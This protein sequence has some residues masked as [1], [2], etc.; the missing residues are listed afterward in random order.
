MKS[1]RNIAENKF[2][3]MDELS[4][5]CIKNAFGNNLKIMYYL[6]EYSV[7]LFGSKNLNI[8]NFYT[9]GDENHYIFYVH[10]IKNQTQYMYYIYDIK[11]STHEF[12]TL[13]SKYIH[14]KSPMVSDKK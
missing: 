13:N 1:I 14:K 5:S 7:I 2:N 9:N 6:I 4:Q 11:K 8:L 12:N 3:K 10:C